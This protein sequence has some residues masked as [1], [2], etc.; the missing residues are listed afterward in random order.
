LQLSEFENLS[1]SNEF[2]E[3]TGIACIDNWEEYIFPVEFF[4][5]KCLKPDYDIDQ[6]LDRYFLQHLYYKQTG[7]RK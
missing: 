1:L 4:E 6:R 3:L 2:Q 7:T 5:L